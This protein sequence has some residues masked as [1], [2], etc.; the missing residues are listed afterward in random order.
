MA[1]AVQ[2]ERRA[3]GH[4]A[5]G[6]TNVIDVASVAAGAVLGIDQVNDV[7][8]GGRLTPALVPPVAT[9]IGKHAGEV[10]R[11]R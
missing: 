11:Q 10:A 6:G 5:V 3:E 7:V 4:S 8:V 1:S 9:A 2:L